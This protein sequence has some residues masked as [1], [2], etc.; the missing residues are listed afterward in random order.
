MSALRKG[1]VKST[2]SR[3][4]TVA[5]PTPVAATQTAT[6]PEAPR[7]IQEQALLAQRLLQIRGIYVDPATALITL[8]QLEVPLSPVIVRTFMGTPRPFIG[9]TL[10]GSAISFD[11]P[12]QQLTHQLAKCLLE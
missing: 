3:P 4:P 8:P 9:G 6:K 7:C 1:M 2:P 10:L 5:T 12:T 11:T